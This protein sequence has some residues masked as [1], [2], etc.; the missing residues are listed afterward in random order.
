M[1]EGPGAPPRRRARRSARHAAAQ[2]RALRMCALSKGLRAARLRARQVLRMINH[3]AALGY[4]EY[5]GEDALGINIV[6]PRVR[7]AA[8]AEPCASAPRPFGAQRVA[9]RAAWRL[10]RAPCRTWW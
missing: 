10:M 3:D 9:P 8:P 7:C 6:S 4:L 1:R 5:Y 2:A